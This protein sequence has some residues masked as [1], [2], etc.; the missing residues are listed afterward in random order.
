M[1]FENL[2]SV[3]KNALFS[4][5]TNYLTVYQIS[6]LAYIG[7]YTFIVNGINYFNSLYTAKYYVKVI[8]NE[9][10]SKVEIIPNQGYPYFKSKIQ[11]IISVNLGES[12][13]LKLP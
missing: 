4:F 13:L 7:N 6:D 8:I 2:T 10:I 3:T 11:S 1:T 5:D 9:A 12:F